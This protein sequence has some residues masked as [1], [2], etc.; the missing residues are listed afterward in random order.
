MRRPAPEPTQAP[1]AGEAARRLND[2]EEKWAG[3]YPSIAPAWR[4]AWAEVTPFYAFSAAIRK[5]IYT[6]N[7][8]ESLN[9]VLRKTLKTKGSFPT[10]EAATKLIFLAIR[11]FERGGRAV[12]EWVAV[13]NQLATMLAGRL[14]A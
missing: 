1:S 7:A 10:E 4:R 6:T 11:N 8:V 14:D 12:R 9:R 5:I 13:R 3:K 2:F